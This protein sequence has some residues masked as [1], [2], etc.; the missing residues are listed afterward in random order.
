[1]T[2]STRSGRPSRRD[3]LV[4]GVGAFVVASIPLAHRHRRQL[5]RRQLPMMGTIADITLLH[6]DVAQG[7]QALDAAF[8]ELASVER[9]MSRF[10][11]DS[12]VGRAN[13]FAAQRAVTISPATFA[14]IES[15]I[16]WAQASDGAFDPAIGRVSELWDVQHRHEPP[17][18]ASVRQL[19]ARHFYRHVQ[20]GHEAGHPVV[21]FSDPDLH[22]DLGAIAKGYAVDR[23]GDALRR[24]GIRQALVNVGG[25]VVAI[26]NGPDGGKWRVGIQSPDDARQLIGTLEVSD[27][28]VAT[29]GDYEQFFRYRGVRYHHLMDPDTAAPR[30]TSEHSVTVVAATCMDAD[31]A[32]TAV[33]GMSRE[34]AQAVLQ[35]R[36]RGARVVSWV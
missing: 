24:A 18:D 5:V 16:R 29:S 23:A 33:F 31:A 26:G 25:E 14:V 8:A 30:R 17:P 27:E 15:A 12:D 35:A 13:R 20:L 36:T 9:T 1:M 28:A 3:F 10:R 7:E 6:D 4:L 32:T 34:R 21:R 2:E 19:A 11:D 22:L